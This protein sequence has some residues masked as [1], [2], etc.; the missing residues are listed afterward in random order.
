MAFAMTAR[1]RRGALEHD[2]R[3]LM[4]AVGADAAAGKTTAARALTTSVST[5]NW[6]EQH[7]S[8]GKKRCANSHNENAKTGVDAGNRCGSFPAAPC[9]RPGVRAHG[10]HQLTTF[11]FAVRRRT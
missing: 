10:R 8:R 2:R 7:P 11:E 4:A 1:H 9:E 5:I 3:Q 6:L